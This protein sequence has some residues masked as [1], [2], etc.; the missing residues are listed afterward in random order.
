MDWRRTEP[1]KVVKVGWRTIVS[2]TFTLPNGKV[3]VFDTLH[4]EGFAAAGVVALTKDNKVITARQFRPGPERLM[5]EIPGG[6]VE[7]GETPEAAARRELLEETGYRAGAL[8]LLGAF[9]RD[10]LM[11][12]EWYYY[13]ATDCELVTKTPENDEHEF[14]DV[15]LKTIPEFIADAK[16]GL[17]TDPEAVLAAYD[18]LTEI[19]K[20]GQDDETTN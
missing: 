15:I 12:G 3:S 10:S 4:N 13:L 16:R 20:E 17:L 18:D 11:N 5:D 8:K 7:E 6:L 19:M 2:K 1:T 14:V 9:N